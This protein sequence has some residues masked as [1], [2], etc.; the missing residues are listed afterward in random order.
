[1][2]VS[3]DGVHSILI[4]DFVNGTFDESGFIDTWKDLHLIPTSVPVIQPPP[5]KTSTVEVPGSNGIVDMTEILV[6][7]PLY[8]NRTGSID[9]YIDNSADDYNSHGQYRWDYAYD[10]LLNTLHGFRKKVILTDA[11]S[12]YYEGRVSVNSYKS[13]K[14]TGTITLD[15]D[16]DPFKMMLFTTTERWKWNPFD[17]AEGK[18]PQNIQ[19]YF[20]CH[21]TEG[22]SQ[23]FGIGND[24]T[25]V[26]P[27][28][29]TITAIPSTGTEVDWTQTMS[30]E[31][32][33]IPGIVFWPDVST[34]QQY[35]IIDFRET[36]KVIDP[37][38]GTIYRITNP[39]ASNGYLLTIGD[40]KPNYRFEWKY[41]NYFRDSSGDIIPTEFLFDFRPRRL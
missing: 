41:K 12:F 3:Y 20:H 21:V 26:V 28:I 17:F 18:I 6:G 35:M 27:L 37:K 38:L 30:H 13:D 32:P 2:Q 34:S 11:R 10:L 22:E 33:T 29:P 8:Q 19:Q 16:L 36:D 5:L 25:G 4:G 9:F 40:P 14:L 15:Y 1:M 24:V 31:P 23:G 7:R 39:T